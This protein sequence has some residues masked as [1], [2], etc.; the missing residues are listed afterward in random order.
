M[1]QSE[2]ESMK[3]NVGKD[4]LDITLEGLEKVWALK[5]SLN[6]PL[7]HIVH[8]DARQPES[9]LLD[10]R[11]PGTHLPGIIRAG[12]YYCRRSGGWQWEFWYLTRLEPLVIELKG[13]HYGRLVLG[14]KD[15]R[16]LAD[17]INGALK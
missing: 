14:V 17:S 10:L 2:G 8:A 6:V 9:S 5:G 12:S 15:A 13:E 16:S 7:E 1:P 4:S 3:A 11:I